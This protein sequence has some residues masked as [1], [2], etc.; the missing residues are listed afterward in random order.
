MAPLPASLS[1]RVSRRLF[2]GGVALG[3]LSLAGCAAGEFPGLGG[4]SGGGTAAPTGQT[5]GSGPVRIA[6]ILPFSSAQGGAVATSL[7]NA[8][9]LALSEFDGQELTILIKDDAG[10][11]QGAAAAARQ[12]MAEGAELVLG[13]LFAPAVAAAA[14]IV[15]AANRPMIAFS[16][17][18]SV[19]QDGV[20]LL[21]FLPQSDVRRVLSFAAQRGRTRFALLAPQMPYGDIAAAQFQATVGQ[22]SGASITLEQRYPAGQ[23]A[24]AA[25]AN[26][27][28]IAGSDAVFIPDDPGAA[29]AAAGAL[30]AARGNAQVLGTGIWNDPTL[31]TNPDIAGAWFPA[32]DGVGFNG[33]A[34]RYEAKFGAAPIRIA[35]LAYDAVALAN[36]LTRTQG[37]ARFSAGI[38]TTASGFGGQDGVFRFRANGLN[39]R[40]LAVFEIA[41]GTARVVS[42]APRSFARAAGG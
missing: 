38:L 21:S 23:L 34:R 24:A 15:R 20:Y 5:L 17:D 10:S 37:D 36:V 35:T 7:R 27:A 28:A 32:P 16:S 39:E 42:P 18:E 12:A 1:G 26:A 3:A 2:S 25:Q 31:F 40:A 19:A 11:P 22:L 6:L 9:E 4:G 8:A 13:P 14:P 30:R 41:G 29:A 33:F